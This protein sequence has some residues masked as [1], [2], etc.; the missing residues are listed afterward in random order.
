LQNLS[1]YDVDQKGVIAIS[2]P[3]AP[4]RR[5]IE[6]VEPKIRNPIRPYPEHRRQ[7]LAID[8]PAV[9]PTRRRTKGAKPKAARRRVIA[10]ESAFFEFSWPVVYGAPHAAAVLGDLTS[11]STV[12]LWA[13]TGRDLRGAWSAAPRA[14]SSAATL[15]SLLLVWTPLGKSLARKIARGCKRGKTH[16]HCYGEGKAE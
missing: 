8:P 9:L 10:L 2:D 11:A 14:G 5:A 7:V 3:F 16:G 6:V 1:G 4:N 15:R 12:A 13:A